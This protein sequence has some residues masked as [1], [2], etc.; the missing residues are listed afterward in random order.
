[1]EEYFPG[2]QFY[3]TVS[4]STLN[5]HYFNKHNDFLSSIPHI[6]LHPGEWEVGCVGFKPVNLEK[7]MDHKGKDEQDRFI[8]RS[9][10]Y[11]PIDEN[12]AYALITTKMFNY[13]QNTGGYD[14]IM[15][16]THDITTLVNEE[17]TSI[18][19]LV[20]SIPDPDP[21]FT[22]P[23]VFENCDDRELQIDMDPVIAVL[24]EDVYV[25]ISFN[26]VA[27]ELFGF[28]HK[29]IT[30]NFDG[31]SG[32][33]EFIFKGLNTP[34]RPEADAIVNCQPA[35]SYYTGQHPTLSW[36]PNPNP[37]GHSIYQEDEIKYHSLLPLPPVVHVHLN[38]IENNPTATQDSC[39][40]RE[41]VLMTA[42]GQEE[43]YIPNNVEYHRLEKSDNVMERMH[44]VI[45]DENYEKLYKT[46]PPPERPL[47]SYND[48]TIVH[49]HFR[50]IGVYFQGKRHK[51]VIKKG[52]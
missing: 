31:I 2:D 52:I 19:E 39:L 3:L 51:D 40:D 48:T 15:N 38:K 17:F 16:N 42:P 30:P 45:T 28:T 46:L 26:Q 7:V 6:K 35:S 9:A 4:S 25:Q 37:V 43:W 47:Y 8:L 22:R 1:M 21:D 36:A 33:T 13:N 23:Y 24:R 11:N 18:N 32:L 14:E 34:P 12:F 27:A 20:F 10:S 41:N 5:N 29:S 50:R 49:L 44:F